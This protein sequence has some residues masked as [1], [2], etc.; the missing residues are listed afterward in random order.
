M[1]TLEELL[2]DTERGEASAISETVA[3]YARVSAALFAAFAAGHVVGAEL[4]AH[5]ELVDRLGEASIAGQQH[6][7]AAGDEKAVAVNLAQTSRQLEFNARV[8][9]AVRAA[10]IHGDPS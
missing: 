8:Q 6:L 3:L 7:Y 10:A 4:P 5:A 2:A 1:S 9:A